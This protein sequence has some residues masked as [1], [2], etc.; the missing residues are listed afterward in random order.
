M[1]YSIDLIFTLLTIC[2]LLMHASTM[3][4][5]GAQCEGELLL[6]IVIASQ[7]QRFCTSAAHDD[8]IILLYVLRHYVV[9]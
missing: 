7:S 1:W 5:L 2:E 9:I 4:T 8:S 6:G 3:L